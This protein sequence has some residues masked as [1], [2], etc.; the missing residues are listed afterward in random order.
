MPFFCKIILVKYRPP[1]VIEIKYHTETKDILMF[2]SFTKEQ[3]TMNRHDCVRKGRPTV[4]V[5]H[6]NNDPTC[7]NFG[8]NEAY[9]MSFFGD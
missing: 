7:V 3:P 2:G 8:H 5:A 1:V 4:I 9:Y 6:P